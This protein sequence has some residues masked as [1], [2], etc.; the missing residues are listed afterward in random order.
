[1]SKHLK[2]TNYVKNVCIY[3]YIYIYEHQDKY[4]YNITGHLHISTKRKWNFLTRF[5]KEDVLEERD[6]LLGSLSHPT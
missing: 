4:G 3:I 6:C 2:N 1:V 5:M